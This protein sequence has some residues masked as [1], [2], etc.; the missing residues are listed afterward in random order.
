MGRGSC[1]Q[2]HGLS[3]I[4]GGGHWRSGARS[5]EAAVVQGWWSKDGSC[6]RDGGVRL[7][8]SCSGS[9]RHHVTAALLDAHWHPTLKARS[10]LGMSHNHKSDTRCPLAILN[11]YEPPS[12]LHLISATAQHHSKQGNPPRKRH[13]R[14]ADYPGV[15]P[16]M[17]CAQGAYASLA[18]E[19]DRFGQSG[20]CSAILKEGIAA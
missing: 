12:P 8:N 18:Y 19:H 7:R 2:G 1:L 15:W 13:A 11:S 17:R 10:L 16:R 9:T 6:R 4:F 3:G 14:R 5:L 20:R